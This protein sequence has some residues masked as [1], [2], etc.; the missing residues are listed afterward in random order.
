MA[1]RPSTTWVS[2]ASRLT[3]QL[4]VFQSRAEV[5]RVFGGSRLKLVDYVSSAHGHDVLM[6]GRP[7]SAEAKPEM[8]VDA[9]A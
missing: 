5:I 7:R 3:G 1:L 8:P 4:D 9:D 6:L 2:N